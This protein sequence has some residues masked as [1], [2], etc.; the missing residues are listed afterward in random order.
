MAKKIYASL[1]DSQQSAADEAAELEALGY[2]NIVI[3]GQGERAKF[4]GTSTQASIREADKFAVYAS[5]GTGW[6]VIK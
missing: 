6:Q 4:I 2:D 1:H 3:V 5:K